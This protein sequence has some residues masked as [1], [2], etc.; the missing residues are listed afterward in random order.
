MANLDG[1]NLL[2]TKLN[3]ANLKGANLMWADLTVAKLD[4]TNLQDANLQGADL[5]GAH[6]LSFDQLSKA[7]TLYNTKLHDEL[8]IPLK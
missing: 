4:A 5:K 3:V 2:Q 1:A 8:L 6:D 7:K